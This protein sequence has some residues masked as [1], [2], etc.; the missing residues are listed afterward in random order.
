MQLELQWA[1]TGAYIAKLQVQPEDSVGSVL[2]MLLAEHALSLARMLYGDADEDA[3][4]PLGEDPAEVLWL[5]HQQDVLN[6]FSTLRDANCKDGDA[7]GLVQ[8]RSASLLL[9]TGVEGAFLWNMAGTPSLKRTYTA[10]SPLSCA[11]ITPDARRVLMC[12]ESGQ[13]AV[14]CATSSTTLCELQGHTDQINHA[15]LSPCGALAVTASRDGS[16]KVWELQTGRLVASFVDHEDDVT[17]AQFSP[18]GQMVLTASDDAT[19]T[20]WNARTGQQVHLL[21]GIDVTDQVVGHSE[22]ILFSGFSPDGTRLLTT[23]EEGLVILWNRSSGRKVWERHVGDLITCGASFIAGGSRIVIGQSTGSILILNAAT[24]CVLRQM[25]TRCNLMTQLV[26]S[27]DGTRCMV[28]GELGDVHLWG[29]AAERRLGSMNQRG[30]DF[31]TAAFIG[32]GEEALVVHSDSIG[33]YCGRSGRRQFY[34]DGI[35]S[36]MQAADA[37]LMIAGSAA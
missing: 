34:V 7:I 8:S 33:V 4:Q 31:S 12:Y 24:G 29:L 3:K 1:A 14:V 28:V 36:A 16:A 2:R 15:A 22:P 35:T 21:G 25:N 27:P 30:G 10:T 23:G 11:C 18:C 26:V 20:L 13:A 9:S 32:T 5:V 37:K 6:E 19:C 17:S